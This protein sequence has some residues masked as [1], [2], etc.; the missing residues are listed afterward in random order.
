MKTIERTTEEIKQ[1]LR[2]P[3]GDIKP[4]QP[5]EV[6]IPT[7]FQK[8]RE[9]VLLQAWSEAEQGHR[10]IMGQTAEVIKAP[11]SPMDPC[12]RSRCYSDTDSGSAERFVD[13]IGEFIAYVYDHPEGGNAG[14]IWLV[15]H[16]TRGWLPDKIGVI[17]RLA[18]A[19][20]DR[21]IHPEAQG[22]ERGWAAKSGSNGSI[23]A[24]LSMAR[25]KR[26]IPFAS[27]DR[28]PYALGLQNCVMDLRTG[29]PRPYNIREIITQRCSVSYN[30]DAKATSLEKCVEGN[31][32]PEDLLLLQEFLGSAL[33]GAQ[34]DRILCYWVGPSGSGKTTI[35]K[36]MQALMGS[37]ATQVDV[38]LYS[39]SKQSRDVETELARLGG[40]RFVFAP[41]CDHHKTLCESR[42]KWLTGGDAIRYRALYQTAGVAENTAKHL[43]YG[44]QKPR[45]EGRDKAFWRRVLLIE[46]T[47][48]VEHGKED[49]DLQEKATKDT[50]ELQGLL[51]WLLEGHKRWVEN[52]MRL[53]LSE[54]ALESR[55]RYE[56]EEDTVGAFLE[57]HTEKQENYKEKMSS[58]YQ[59]Y[60]GWAESEGL[61]HILSAKAFAA[62][63]DGEY[64]RAKIKG[65][66]CWV[67]LKL[68]GDM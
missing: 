33:N 63:L 61:R 23:T 60:K 44:N 68:R 29:T 48:G 15:W 12:F 55:K 24:M 45:V 32:N 42:I 18:K 39:T 4:P 17:R 57:A 11:L 8:Q 54:R 35:T 56:A 1:A 34:R 52:G 59:S 25:S 3:V 7:D 36:A 43:I 30:P 20:S 26:S 49:P 65:E 16:P 2:A 47:N 50:L 37:Y 21:M 64:E 53:R 5:V 58:V 31:Y 40:K 10:Q 46:A 27:L 38:D 41:E 9:Q 22:I 14:G 28:D 6:P 51:N 13:W 67:G 19:M 66:R 62:A